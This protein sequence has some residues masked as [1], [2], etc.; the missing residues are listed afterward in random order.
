MTPGS[1]A[2]KSHLLAALLAVAISA[3]ALAAALAWCDQL[4]TRYIHAI[5]PE[6]TEEKLQGVALQRHAFAEPDL[7]VLYGSS[8]LVKEM[9]NNA[10]Q[11]FQDYPTGFRVFPVGKPGTSSLAI[12]QK[13]AAVGGDIRGEKTAYSMSP[14]WFFTET[15][16]PT[17]YEGNFS[18][19]QAFELTFNS[20]LS[21]RLKRDVARR[22]LAFPKTIDGRPLL[23]FGLRHLAGDTALDRFLY[24]LAWPLGRMKVGVGRAQDHFETALHILD[25]DEQLNPNPTHGLRA[26]N[27]NQILKQAARFA[28]AA[29]V[30]AKKNEVKRKNLP[31]ASRDKTFITEMSRAHEWTDVELLMR[32]F[33]ELGAKPLLLSMPIEDIR[34]EVYG[35][36]PD[37]R[38]AYLDR[39]HM[40]AGRYDIPLVD[41]RDHEKDN[42]FTVDF[43]DHLSGEG[44]LYY[45]KVLDDFYHDRLQKL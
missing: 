1:P 13:V 12:L 29:S 18:A 20:H 6:F 23:D 35:I 41:F 7:L 37:A 38:T 2:Q 9:P 30:Q 3:V 10:S 28:N 19:L 34:L 4:E 11:F 8:E 44:W 14:G 39:L 36:S 24:G 40:L 31:R 45:N 17:W 42:G 32:T 21:H 15:F 26:L 43:L 22:M 25:E 5:A 33:N 16:D 27:W